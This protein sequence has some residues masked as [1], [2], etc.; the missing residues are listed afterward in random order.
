MRFRLL[1]SLFWFFFFAWLLLQVAFFISLAERG[2][3]PIDYLAYQRGAEAIERG[4]SPYLPPAQSREIFRY[5]H[6]VEAELLAANARGEGRVFLREFAAR[7]PQPGPYIYPP[8]L[9]LLVSQLHIRPQV[10]TGLLLL[11]ILGFVAI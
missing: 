5:F 7:P 8:T 9:A 11:S 1:P 2:Q 10:F 3:T 4:E 6:Q